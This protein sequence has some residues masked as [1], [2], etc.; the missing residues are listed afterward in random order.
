MMMGEVLANGG[1]RVLRNRGKSLPVC[2][3]DEEGELQVAA[4][5]GRSVDQKDEEDW[6]GK[7]CEMATTSLAKEEV[8][9]QL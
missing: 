2:G 1:W 6:R 8:W 9:G 5:G 7:G 4:S 3:E